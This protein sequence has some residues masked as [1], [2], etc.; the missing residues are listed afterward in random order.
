MLNSF[1]ILPNHTYVFNFD[2][3]YTADI[4]TDIMDYDY[5]TDEPPHTYSSHFNP[6]K[7]SR[8]CMC[9]HTHTH[10]HT[11]GIYLSIYLSIYLIM[12]TEGIQSD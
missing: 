4:R 5:T 10:T 3:I 1:C 7:E 9:T 2:R 11:S 6:Y 12:I 8:Y